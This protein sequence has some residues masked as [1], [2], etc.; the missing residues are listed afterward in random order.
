MEDREIKCSGASNASSTRNPKTKFQ[1]EWQYLHVGKIWMGLKF[2]GLFYSLR[3]SDTNLFNTI[4]T[5]QQTSKYMRQEIT[6]NKLHPEGKS[7]FKNFK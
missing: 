2:S 1:N 5:N 6:L 7:N 4:E 3:K